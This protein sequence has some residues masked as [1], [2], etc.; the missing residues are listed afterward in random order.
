MDLAPLSLYPPRASPPP[1]PSAPQPTAAVAT[2]PNP[3][4]PRP[5]PLPLGH[6]PPRHHPQLSAPTS[7]PPLILYLQAVVG[8][9]EH[10]SRDLG[11]APN[12]DGVELGDLLAQL[13]RRH[14]VEALDV[15]KAAKEVEIAFSEFYFEQMVSS[16]SSSSY[17]SSCSLLAASVVE[18]LGGEGRVE[19]STVQP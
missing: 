5:S 9:Q 2:P 18:D 6:R 7:K 1:P 10:L 4:L 17:F 8:G 11:T 13:L 16:I 14:A 19:T 15:A 3:R 12:D